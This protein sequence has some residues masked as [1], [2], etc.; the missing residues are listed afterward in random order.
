V[1]ASPR[2]FGHIGIRVRRTIQAEGV[3]AGFVYLGNVVYGPG[4]AYLDTIVAGLRTGRTKVIGTGTNRLPVTSVT[5]AAAALVHLAARPRIDLAGRS[6]LA[7]PPSPIT[8]RAFLDATAD[9]L[10]ARRPDAVPTSLA[11]LVAGRVNADVMTLD[12]ACRPTAL[13]A[14]GFRFT[15]ADLAAGITAALATPQTVPA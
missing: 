10:G 5:D 11:A 4:K 6:Y 13:T 2:G 8:Q 14:Q 1:R 7:V 12:A 3:D 15:H 9:A